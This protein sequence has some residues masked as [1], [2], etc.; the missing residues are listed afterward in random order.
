MAPEQALAEPIDGRADLY[1]L[2]IILYEM[3]AGEPPFRADSPLVVLQQ[4]I[5]REPPPLSASGRE[6][7]PALATLV[8]RCLA[9]R[10]ESRFPSMDHFID[11]LLRAQRGTSVELPLAEEVDDEPVVPPRG[12]GMRAYLALALALILGAVLAVHYATDLRTPKASTATPAPA[13][14]GHGIHFAFVATVSVA[15]PAPDEP[16]ELM[17][18]LRDL[19]PELREALESGAL[20]ARITVTPAGE[21]VPVHESRHGVERNGQLS[22]V[23]DLPK[24]GPHTVELVLERAERELDRARF[25]LFSE[26]TP[27]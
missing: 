24:R 4:H 22:V 18:Q 12:G 20:G 1:A 16:F 9:K 8:M 27:R 13:I 25:E 21:R 3:L 10:P 5:S 17:I 19:D 23:L 6:V 14:E 11:A 26:H 7:P 2:G 15:A